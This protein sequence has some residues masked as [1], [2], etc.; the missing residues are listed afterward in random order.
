M[1]DNSVNQDIGR[2]VARNVSVM[3]IAQ[4]VTWVSSFVL[5]YYLPRYLGSE[6]FGR[7]YLALSIKMMLSLL[8]DF[9][10]NYL[11]PKEVARSVKTGM[12]VL[13]NYLILRVILWVFSIGL[14]LLISDMLGYSDHVHLLILIL[15]IGKLWEGGTSALSA[16]YQGIERMEYPS[17]GNIIEKM[18]VAIFAVIALLMGGD[19]TAV[20]IIFTGGAFV[21]LVILA[22]FSRKTVRVTYK[23]DVNMVSLLRS[24]MP[25]FL[26]SLFSVIYYRIDAIMISAMTSDMVTGWYGGAFRFFDIVMVLPLLYKTAIFPVFSKLWNN[27]EG[28]LESTVSESLRLMIL[29]GFPTALLICIYASPVIHFFMGLEEY[30]PSVLILQIFAISI[31]IIY[32]DIILGSALMGAANRQKAWAVVG[33]VAIFVNIGVNFLLIPYTQ[34]SFGNGGIGAAVATLF[35]ELFVMFCALF[36]VPSTYLKP[37]KAEYLIKPATASLV[38]VGAIYLL[39]QINLYWMISALFA[40]FIYTGTLF[41]LKTFNKDEQHLIRSF[42]TA[43]P[44]KFIL[45]WRD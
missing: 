29:L 23:T 18:L 20:A 32:V 21:N 22:W 31:P 37:F 16:Y 19:S 12:H 6:D 9:G 43:E 17:I 2:S 3:F 45:I 8:I 15:A 34:A 13:S 42:I 33:F 39:F 7:L 5:L 24:G 35:T 14:I 26:F 27:K 25:F 40:V 36:L 4:A 10:G 28:V 11:I 1:N 44:F 38:M 30:G 41:L